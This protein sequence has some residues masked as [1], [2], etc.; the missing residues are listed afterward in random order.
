MLCINT[1]RR[2]FLTWKDQLTG[3]KWRRKTSNEVHLPRRAID[4]SVYFKKTKSSEHAIVVAFLEE[5]SR[6]VK[7]LWSSLLA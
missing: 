4:I 5:R 2:N 7:R 3:A 1:V 6:D